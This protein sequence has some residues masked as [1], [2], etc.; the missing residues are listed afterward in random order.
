MTRE[1]ASGGQPGLEKKGWVCWSLEGEDARVA[2]RQILDLAEKVAFAESKSS[3]LESEFGDLKSDLETT[4]N[5]R[6]TLGTAYDE[7]IKSLNEQ[8]NEL[9]GKY[10]A[11][12]D[13]LDV[14]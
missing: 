10:V 7:Q 11:V 4:R 3:K 5:E 13:R 12:D 8:I 2:H 6:D 9:T 14:E 1:E